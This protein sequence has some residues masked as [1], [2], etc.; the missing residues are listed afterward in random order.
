MR[1]LLTGAGGFVGRALLAALEQD[2]HDITLLSRRRCSVPGSW[3]EIVTDCSDWPQIVKA[4][5]FDVCVHLAWIATPGEYLESIE[6]DAVASTTIA[7]AR[8]LFFNGLAHFIGVGSGIEYAPDQTKACSEKE[9]PVAPQTTYGKSKERART[10]I[11]AAAEFYDAGYTWARL[12]YPFGVGEHP[13]RIPS[14]FLRTLAAGEKLVLGTPNSVKD[15]ISIEDVVSALIHLIER[16]G[17]MREVNLGSGR[18]VRIAELA[19][20]ASRLVGADPRLIECAENPPIDPYAFHVA[21]MTRLSDSGWLAA[22]PLTTSL[23]RLNN[24]FSTSP[25]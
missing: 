7:L 18:G 17:P 24:Q 3:R 12:F 19:Q 13:R 1:I 25:L 15:F 2:Q 9:T 23:E 22:T 14:T 21:D 6:N 10:G 5:R 16:S 4:E 11:A 20:T 8:S